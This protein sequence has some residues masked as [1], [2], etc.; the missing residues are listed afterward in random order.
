[1]FLTCFAHLG[2]FC[3]IVVNS[4]IIDKLI[5]K[6][7]AQAAFFIAITKAIP[8]RVALIMAYTLHGIT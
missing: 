1:M 6:L 3:K 7:V 5:N 4:H 2:L 8:Y